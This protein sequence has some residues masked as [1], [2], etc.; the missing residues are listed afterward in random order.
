MVQGL[1]FVPFISEEFHKI[2]CNRSLVNLK[3]G[4]YKNAERD[5]QLCIDCQP[6][7]VKVTKFS[8]FASTLANL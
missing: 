1:S 3:M 4:N 6:G 5:A 2:I 7:F 8:S